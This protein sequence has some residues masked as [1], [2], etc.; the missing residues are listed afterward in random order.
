MM[1]GYQALYYLY[2]N[3]DNESLSFQITAGFLTGI[4]S[5]NIGIY[6]VDSVQI[7]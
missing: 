6:L 2:P 3:I 7:S 4:I 5:A 1:L